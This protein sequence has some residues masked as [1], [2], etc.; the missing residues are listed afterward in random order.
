[1]S[2]KS[3]RRRLDQ[4]QALILAAERRVAAEGEAGL[5]ARELARDVGI[6]VGAIYNLVPDLVEL[7]FHV[8]LRTLERL[9]QALAE[10]AASAPPGDP[11]ETL[12]GIARGYLAFARENHNLWRGAFAY[13]G[14][15]GRVVPDWLVAVQMRLFGRVLAPL[16]I[17]M[18]T[19][20]SEERRIF[21]H[22]LFTAAHGVIDMGLQQRIFAVPR[23]ALEDQLTFLL[24]AICGGLKD[25]AG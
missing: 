9:D 2:E 22:T 10:G 17:L 18:P 8:T 16:E 20:S 23:A 1:M 3:E 7:R 4:K 5:K 15:E 25:G 11:V 24:R 6:A 21:A 14:P 19:A 12:V 13:L